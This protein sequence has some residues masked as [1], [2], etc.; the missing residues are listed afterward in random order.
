M[1]DLTGAEILLACPP[2]GP[3]LTEPAKPPTHTYRPT[4]QP[5]Q[6]AQQ[7]Q[8]GRLARTHCQICNSVSLFLRLSVSISISISL[9]VSLSS[10]PPSSPPSP[11]LHRL[12]TSGL[13]RAQ[14]RRDA[15]A[16]TSNLGSV[17]GHSNKPARPSARTSARARACGVCVCQCVSVSALRLE[18]KGKRAKPTPAALLTTRS[19]ACFSLYLLCSL[20]RLLASTQQSSSVKCRHLSFRH[21]RHHLFTAGPSG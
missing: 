1:S 9:S 19:L 17:R 18:D 20:A 16:R 5:L 2:A 11:L 6:P 8:A 14:D 4:N 15:L 3:G 13:L 10:P 21:Y 7:Q 12:A